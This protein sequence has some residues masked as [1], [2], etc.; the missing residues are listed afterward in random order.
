MDGMSLT[1]KRI[2]KHSNKVIKEEFENLIDKIIGYS[3]A[4]YCIV[5]CVLCDGKGGLIAGILT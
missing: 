1:H 5:Y 4:V 3:S 2:G